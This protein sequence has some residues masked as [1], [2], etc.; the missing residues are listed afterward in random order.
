MSD[1]AS[2]LPWQRWQPDDLAATDVAESASSEREYD[3]DITADDELTSFDEQQQQLE[4]LAQQSRQEASAR[5]YSEGHQTGFSEGQ[6]SGYSAGFEQGL[7]EAQQQQAPLQAQM[8]KLASEFQQ[9]LEELDSVVAA[10][11][12]QLALQAARQVIGE[13]VTIDGQ[14]LLHHIQ[15]LLQQEP[16]LNGKPQL[17]VHPDD[18]ALVEETLGATLAQQGWRLLADSALHPGGCKLSAED[19]DLDASLA[20]RWQA[21]CQLAEPGARQ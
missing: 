2:R 12:M 3:T 6:Q 14:A 4:R 19:G 18:L 21:I 20:T 8:Q 10:R 13:T 11:L 5:G 9:A 7:A 1:A 16:L 15:Q 17:R